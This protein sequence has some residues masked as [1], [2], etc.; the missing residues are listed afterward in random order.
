MGI[1]RALRRGDHKKEIGGRLVRRAEVDASRDGHSR[2]AGAQ[3]SAA[4][5]VGHRDPVSD[6]G[7]AEF[8]TREK[9]GAVPRRIAQISGLPLKRDQTVQRLL[10]AGGRGAETDG[11]LGKQIYNPHMQKSFLREFGAKGG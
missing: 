2:Q 11:I 3:H 10:P 4:F 9:I 7:R 6:R 8:L 5:G 1:S